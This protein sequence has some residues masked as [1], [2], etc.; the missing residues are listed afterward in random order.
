MSVFCV[1]F[2][3][4]THRFGLLRV[5][6]PLLTEYLLVS[7]PPGTEMFYFPGCAFL[8]LKEELL[9]FT[10]SG[11]PIRT[12]PDQRLLG[13]SPKLIAAKLR[14]SSP[15]RVK[16]STICSLNFLLGNLKTTFFF[17]IP[18]SKKRNESL[19][20]FRQNIVGT[21]VIVLSLTQ[22]NNLYIL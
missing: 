15:F 20:S 22:R 16:A 18:T 3:D 6:S 19:L 7:T 14:P 10:Q 5:R 1:L 13:T 21:K 4:A 2:S 11:F 9:S 12:S 17:L 8:F